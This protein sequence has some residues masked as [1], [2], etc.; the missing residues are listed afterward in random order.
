MF[1]NVSKKA[2]VLFMAL[3]IPFL[4]FSQ[5]LSEARSAIQ[6][7]ANALFDILDIIMTIIFAVGIIGVVWAYSSSNQ[8]AKDHLT[9]FVI[10]IVIGAIGK[11]L[12][13]VL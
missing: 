7:E 10:A 9:K 6:Q 2:A 13:F 11:A 3:F 12:F 1:S 4:T 5:S 8:N